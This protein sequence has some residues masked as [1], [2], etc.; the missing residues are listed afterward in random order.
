MSK[1][2]DIKRAMRPAE[3]EEK[4]F[5]ALR[6]AFE[7]ALAHP[8]SPPEAR[9]EI[10]GVTWGGKPYLLAIVVKANRIFSFEVD[11]DPDLSSPVFDAYAQKRAEWEAE[12]ERTVAA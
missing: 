5:A 9:I 4:E 2:S 7:R 6:E 12:K 10:P 8:K 3:M 1:W 11:H